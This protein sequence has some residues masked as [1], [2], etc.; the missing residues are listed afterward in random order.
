MQV[1]TPLAR[2]LAFQGDRAL[3]PALQEERPGSTPRARVWASPCV[4]SRASRAFSAHSR[5][6]VRQNGL[7]WAWESAIRMHP[8]LLAQSHTWRGKGFLPRGQTGR[9]DARQKL[10]SG[11][12]V[13]DPASREEALSQSPVEMPGHPSQAGTATTVP[14][15]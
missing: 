14:G 4:A 7:Q 3:S 9:P 10:G 6:D 11:L 5:P 1:S 8:R 15:C 2:E 12:R 13:R